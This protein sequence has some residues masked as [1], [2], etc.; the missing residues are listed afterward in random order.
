MSA[1]TLIAALIAP[2]L[3]SACVKLLPE[4]AE[5]PRLYPLEAGEV[6]ALA[7]A[8][9]TMIAAVAAPSGPE[10]MMGDNIVWRRDG[11]IA[12]MSGAAWAGRAP[13]LL[14]AMLAETIT[15]QA[16]L[17]V[18]VRMGDGLRGDVEVRWDIIAFE[19]V[20][21][22]GALDARF[23]AHVRVQ[24]TAGRSLLGADIIDIR[25]P[26][27]QR[28]GSAAANAL[29]RAAREG[30]ARIGVMAAEAADRLQADQA[31]AESTNR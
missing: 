25:E 28:S 8:R 31:S 2:L 19:I 4:P 1:K 21:E 17:A 11:E 12:F 20:E 3:L 24:Q 15:R 14:Q 18:G 27:S 13:D 23:A 30:S 9:G 5:P 26:L 7:P 10:A 16:R 22:G 6:H 29:A